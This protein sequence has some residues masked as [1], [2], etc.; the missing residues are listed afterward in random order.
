MSG[1]APFF[2]LKTFLITERLSLPLRRTMAIPPEPIGVAMA[3][4]V[5]SNV[6]ILTP[7]LT[8]PHPKRY[9]LVGGREST[10]LPPWQLNYKRPYAKN[11]HEAITPKMDFLK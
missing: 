7:T 6:F 2:P 11:K 8:L 3:A 1:D 9:P 10:Y 5:S 4:I